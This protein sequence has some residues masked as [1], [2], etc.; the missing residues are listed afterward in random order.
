[1]FDTKAKNLGANGAQ[2]GPTA[3]SAQLVSSFIGINDPLGQNPKGTPFTSNIFNLFGAW[4]NLPGNGGV[5]AARESVARGE[6]LFNTTPITITGVAGLNDNPAV[7]PT[8]HGFCGT[9]HDTPNVGDHSVK[10]PLDIGIADAV[11]RHPRF[12]TSRRCR[13]ST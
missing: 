6:A 1:M 12:W 3:L 7:G 13:S 8:L 11:Q 2:G 4:D 10:A 9:C 5:Q